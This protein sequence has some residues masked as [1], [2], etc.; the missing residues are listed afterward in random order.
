M[1]RWHVLK[2]CKHTVIHLHIPDLSKNTSSISLK[3]I[4]STRRNV[5]PENHLQKTYYQLI[6]PWEWNHLYIRAGQCIW[7]DINTKFGRIASFGLNWLR[8]FSTSEANVRKIATDFPSL[9]WVG[10]GGG[11]Y[12]LIFVPWYVRHEGCG[13][14]PAGNFL[15]SGCQPTDR[16]CARCHADIPRSLSH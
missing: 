4:A 15:P 2:V 13:W 14:T 9:L 8:K 1:V 3:K 12:I 7:G 16:K 10:G 11:T 5:W 6:T